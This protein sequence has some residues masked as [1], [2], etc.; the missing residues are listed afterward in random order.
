LLIVNK[1]WLFFIIIYVIE[2]YFHLILAASESTKS[3]PS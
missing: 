3:A 2:N 1:L